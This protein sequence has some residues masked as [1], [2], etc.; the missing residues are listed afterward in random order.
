MKD[1]IA[2]I[3]IG[4]C[5]AGIA[6]VQPGL[7]ATS[8]KVRLRDDV[9]LIP[10][11][12][13]V[14]AIALGYDAAMVDLTWTRLLLEYGRHWSDRKYF[15]DA[16][17]FI[18][19]IIEI[20]PTFAAIY[21]YSDTFLTYQPTPDKH[22]T[23]TQA[24]AI[25]ARGYLE[26]GLKMRPYDHEL[27]LHYGQYLAFRG[28]AFFDLNAPEWDSWRKDGALAIM[29]AAELGASID[30]TMAAAS[31]LG[32]SGEQAATV[33]YLERAYALTDDEETKERI[34]NQ[35]SF[36]KK[37]VLEDAQVR[38]QKRLDS[39]RGRSYPFLNRHAFLLVGP[40]PDT[41]GCAGDRGDP[42]CSFSWSTLLAK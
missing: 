39:A 19:V 14:K 40:M 10:S 12:K 16:G 4:T 28:N 6:Y 18:D 23:G 7:A 26:R 33:R 35:L 24:D 13:E 22:S 34:A 1:V 30:K 21:M 17:R 42:N 36:Y 2:A 8:K 25:A 9:V 5:A 29:R 15:R 38:A 37:S 3:V 11:P 41:F 32:K 27:W 31:I 20:E